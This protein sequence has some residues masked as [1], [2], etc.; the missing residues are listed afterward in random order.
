VLLVHLLKLGQRG[1]GTHNLINKVG[2]TGY[3]FWG[4]K[5]GAWFYKGGVG[6]WGKGVT[7]S[8]GQSFPCGGASFAVY[9][10]FLR[11]SEKKTSETGK[12]PSDSGGRGRQ[13]KRLGVQKFKIQDPGPLKAKSK[14]VFRFAQI[15][16][17][18]HKE[19][20]VGV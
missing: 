10:E 16:L 9:N 12:N 14:E 15:I 2:I 3:R 13:I 11:L 4:K 5:K 18:H 7:S 1:L 20:I 8:W 17:E 6:T 19:G